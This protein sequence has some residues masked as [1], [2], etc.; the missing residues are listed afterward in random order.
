MQDVF[1][2]ASYF[3]LLQDKD[4]GDFISNLKLQKLC[5][6]A[7]GIH[8][9]ITNQRL[10]DNDIEAWQHGPVVADLY[11]EYNQYGSSDIP[12]TPGFSSDIISVENRELLD[13]VYAEYG[14][15]SAWKLRNMTHC[16]PPWKRAIERKERII[17]DQDMIEFFKT[18]IC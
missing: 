4:C 5:Y 14:Q 15:Y 7:Q 13:D 9:A 18:Q 3:L 17:S 16:E 11:F 1:D 10:F 6:Y 2:V 12:V 8:L